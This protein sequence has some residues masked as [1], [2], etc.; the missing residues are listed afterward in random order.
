MTL[1]D[2][3]DDIYSLFLKYFKRLLKRIRDFFARSIGLLSLE[4]KVDTEG[5]TIQSLN[6]ADKMKMEAE[7][8]KLFDQYADLKEEVDNAYYEA[9]RL[10]AIKELVTGYSYT[11]NVTNADL[12]TVVEYLAEREITDYSALLQSDLFKLEEYRSELSHL[13][14]RTRTRVQDIGNRYFT[15]YSELSDPLREKRYIWGITRDRKTTPACVEIADEIES[16][17]RAN[18]ENGVTLASLRAIVQR[19]SE[20]HFP[21]FQDRYPS[22]LVAHYNCRSQ[23][24]EVPTY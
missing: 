8:Q 24:L 13:Q 1:F 7:L 20:E 19:I 2:A 4:D 21:G 9:F 18:A 10:E 12:V 14:T 11:T 6:D 15:L 22:G 17:A 16:I 3:G 5:S 23:V